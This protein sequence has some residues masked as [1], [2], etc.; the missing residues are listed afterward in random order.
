MI[1]VVIATYNGQKYIEEQLRS[2]LLQT[3]RPDE[4]LIFDDGSTDAPA[5]IVIRFI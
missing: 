3:A 2:V 4:V 1:S 5:E